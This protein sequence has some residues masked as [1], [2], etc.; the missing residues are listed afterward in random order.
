MVPRMDD[1]KRDAVE[2]VKQMLGNAE[3]NKAR[4]R[5]AFRGMTHEQ[6]QVQYGQSGSTRGEILEGYSKDVERWKR[7]LAWVEAAR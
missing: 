2:A 1:P 4:A 3:D 7:A 5:M 6:L